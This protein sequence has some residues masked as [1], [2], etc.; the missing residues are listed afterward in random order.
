MVELQREDVEDVCK[1]L[2]DCARQFFGFCTE[3]KMLLGQTLSLVEKEDAERH[4]KVYDQFY[5]ACIK[6]R[7]VAQKAL[8]VSGEGR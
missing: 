5:R 4:V 8:T 6:Y 2:E 1:L 3:Q 7:D